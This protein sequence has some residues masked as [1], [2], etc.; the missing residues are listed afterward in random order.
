MLVLPSM[1]LQYFR[2]WRLGQVQSDIITGYLLALHF[3][4]GVF[5]NYTAPSNNSFDRLFIFKIQAFFPS[6][7]HSLSD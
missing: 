5:R 1:L 7:L 6:D 3:L 4:Y 2:L